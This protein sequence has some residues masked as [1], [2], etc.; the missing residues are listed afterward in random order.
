M[1]VLDT[2]IVTLLSY[3]RS[4]QLQRRIAEAKGEDLAVTIIT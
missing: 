1:I 2:D 4:D 3:G